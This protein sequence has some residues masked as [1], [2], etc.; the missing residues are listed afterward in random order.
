M[1][2]LPNGEFEDIFIR[3]DATQ[4]CDGQTP[5]DSIGRAY[6]SHC[7]AKMFKYMYYRHISFHL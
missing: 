3:F 2:W 1:A 6:T 4:E 5:H 7:A